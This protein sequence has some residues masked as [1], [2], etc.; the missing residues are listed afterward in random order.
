MF[1]GLL[2][3]NCIDLSQVEAEAKRKSDL[4]VKI[5][6]FHSL[7]HAR[8]EEEMR[9]FLNFFQNISAFD[10]NDIKA[11]NIIRQEISNI[12][13][14]L[15]RLEPS[16][17]DRIG[18]FLGKE[19]S[20]KRF[21]IREK[22][23]NLL[24]FL[25]YTLI[26]FDK[27]SRQLPNAHNHDYSGIFF[28]RDYYD[29]HSMHEGFFEKLVLIFRYLAQEKPLNPEG[30]SILWKFDTLGFDCSGSIFSRKNSFIMPHQGCI[31]SGQRQNQMF[32]RKNKEVLFDQFGP[33]DCTSILCELY[34]ELP[35]K[36]FTTSI[37][38][39]WI[40]NDLKQ[41][42]NAA[43]IQS[44]FEKVLAKTALI[45]PGNLLL[46]K[47]HV[48]IIL[49]AKNRYLYVINYIRDDI[50][51]QD[52]SKNKNGFIITALF[53]PLLEK[54]YKEYCILKLLV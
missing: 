24:E 53:W 45:E 36:Y 51:Y 35:V 22:F 13:K 6:K 39:A 37:V 33:R 28:S 50:N 52:Q 18:D 15:K 41:Y 47:D 25:D 10:I 16:F 4:C 23:K 42:K 54:E 21:Q 26:F 5:L 31:P 38:W 7:Y 20:S 14:I 40:K 19:T 8:E 48:W 34:S 2:I 29:A 3:A 46:I 9:E 32:S 1:F 12:Q 27:I 44:K 30:S 43:E 49:G 11:K 17:K